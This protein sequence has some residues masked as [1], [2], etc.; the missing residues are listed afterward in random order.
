M[1]CH[2]QVF[3]D[4]VMVWMVAVQRPHVHGACGIHSDLSFD[5]DALFYKAMYDCQMTASSCDVR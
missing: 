1:V 3:S 5:V 4:P 2:G